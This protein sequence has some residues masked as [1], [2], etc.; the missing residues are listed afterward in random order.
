M[1]FRRKLSSFAV[2]AGLLAGC[3]TTIVPEARPVDPV[4]VYIADYGIHSSLMLPVRSD[5]YVEYCFGD[6]GYAAENHCWP[7]DAVGALLVSCQSALGRRFFDLTPGETSPRPPEHPKRLMQVYA[8]RAD[9]D[10]LLDQLNE[11]FSK[12]IDTLQ[13]NPS[14]DI[15]YVKDD[16]HYSWWNNCND[17]T[18]HGLRELHCEVRGVVGTSKFHIALGAPTIAPT[19]APANL[20]TAQ[21]PTDSAP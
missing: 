21:T 19:T 9:V 14:N 10:H 6:W 17:L 5:R 15:E 2:L 4:P 1:R 16:E 7:H 3:S 13:Y 8:A 20:E 12:S 18:A 11:R